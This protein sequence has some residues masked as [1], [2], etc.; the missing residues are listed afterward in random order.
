MSTFK[1]HGCGEAGKDEFVS[2]VLEVEGRRVLVERIPER[3]CT[4]SVMW[5]SRGREPNEPL[6]H[7]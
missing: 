5:C 4:R 2:E 1:C 3:V 6:S 7:P